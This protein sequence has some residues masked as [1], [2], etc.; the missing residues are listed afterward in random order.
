MFGNLFVQNPILLFRK[1]PLFSLYGL[2][3]TYRRNSVKFT[4]S[5]F[6]SEKEHMSVII[7]IY[8]KSTGFYQ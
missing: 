2:L 4:N 6:G 3:E 7:W 5:G 8:Q 1:M